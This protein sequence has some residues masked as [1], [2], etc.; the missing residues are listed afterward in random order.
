MW[1]MLRLSTDAE[2]KNRPALENDRDR[3]VWTNFGY[4]HRQDGA[5]FKR[6]PDP[7]SRLLILSYLPIVIIWASL[8][9]IF[10]LS[11]LWAIG[12][13][14]SSFRAEAR[15]GH[16]LSTGLNDLFNCSIVHIHGSNASLSILGSVTNFEL[17]ATCDILDNQRVRWSNFIFELHVYET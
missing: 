16:I 14:C 1:Y 12:A 9:D 2:L 4:L 5:E 11:C 7:M 3:L 8:A 13:Q 10:G 6:V 15:L 17:S